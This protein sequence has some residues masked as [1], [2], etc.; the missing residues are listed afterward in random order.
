MLERLVNLSI[1]ASSLRIATPILLA[2]LAG[3]IS[4]RSGVINIGIEGVML[5]S[6]FAAA[7]GSSFLGAWPGVL[8]GVAVGAAFGLLHAFM[9]VTVR[10]NQIV[11]ATAINILAIG[12][13][14]I[15]ISRVW[16]G[17]YSTTPIVPV[18]PSLHI[19]WLARVPVLGSIFRDLNPVVYLA[20]LLVPVMHVLLFRTR[21]GLRIRAVGELP[22]AA[23]TLGVNVPRLRYLSVIGSGALAGLGGVYLSICYQSQ[24]TMGMTEGRGFIGLAAMIFGRWTPVGAMVSSLLFGL[25]DAF[26]AN[27]QSAGLPIPAE[28]MLTLP[29]VLTLLALAGVAG[30]RVIGPAAAGQPYVKH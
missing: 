5:L 2:A 27:A 24:F 14:N 23:D 28:I 13:P 20:F 21:A 26:Q 18:V 4:E 10:S 15:I 8:V 19:R 12:L 22:I 7:L 1:I 6:A 30:K 16:Q 9:S 29:Y 17:Y 11:N 25:A 3:T